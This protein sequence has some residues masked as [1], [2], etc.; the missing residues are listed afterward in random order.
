[1]I[2]DNAENRKKYDAMHPLFAAAMDFAW[3][4]VKKDP[5]P[6]R[7]P[8]PGTDKAYVNVNAPYTPKPGEDAL[9]E[10]HR[11]YIDIQ[12]VYE[13]SEFILLGEKEDCKEQKPFDAE[14][15]YG[16]YALPNPEK[17]TVFAMQAG[18][19][20]IFFPGE[21]HAPGVRSKESVT[22]KKAVV[23]VKLS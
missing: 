23:K 19:F 16:L 10:Y 6:G 17:T 12:I 5:A 11:D 3:E 21:L 13:G 2:K 22:V 7:Y 8:V 15:D 9:M 14:N 20:A 18:D 1:M 4:L